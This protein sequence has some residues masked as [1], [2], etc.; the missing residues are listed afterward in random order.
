MA[1]LIYRRDGRQRAFPLTA[2]RTVVGRRPTV[3]RDGTQDLEEHKRLGERKVSRAGVDYIV[4]PAEL[5]LSR[6]HFEVQ[7]TAGGFVIRDL[8]SSGGTYVAGERVTVERP[9]QDGDR[10]LECL[11]FRAAGGRE[12][13]SRGGA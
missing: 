13:A 2:G 9:L 4:L 10:I 6:S 3:L 1:S 12:F 7:R 11:E 8:E 5:C